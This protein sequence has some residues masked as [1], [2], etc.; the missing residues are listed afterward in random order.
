L[1]PDERAKIQD[2]LI[3][4]YQFPTLSEPVAPSMTPEQLAVASLS[5]V[6]F[7]SNEFAYVD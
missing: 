4:R 5:V 3:E 1:S 7:N 6:L 2:D